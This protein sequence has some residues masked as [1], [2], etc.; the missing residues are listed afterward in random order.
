MPSGR[1]LIRKAVKYGALAASAVAAV[2]IVQPKH[3][4]RRNYPVLGRARWLMES[5]RPEIQQYFVESNT[6]GRPFDRVTRTMVYQ[7]AKN[8]PAEEAFGT[9]RDLFVPGHD[10]LLH[11]TH[12]VPA[13]TDAPLV[14]LGGPECTQPYDISLFNISSMSFGSLSANAVLAMNKGAA[15]GGFIQETGEGGLTKY[16]LEYGAD[17]IWEIGSS[18]FGCR[19]EDGHFDPEQFRVKANYPEVKGILIKLSQGAK[20]GMGGMLP[21]HKVTAEIAE[22]RGIEEGQDCL[23]PAWH[24]EFDTPLELMHFVKKLRRL[25][26]GKPVGIKFCVGSRHEVLSLCKAMLKAKTAPDWITVDGAEGGTGAAPLEFLDRVGTPLTE[27]LMIVHNALVG[28]GLRDQVAVGAAGKVVGGADIIRRLAIGADFTMS[29]RGMMM[30]AGCIQAKK[31]HDNTCPTGVATQNP[32]LARGLDVDSKAE[33][34]ANYHR[35]TLK[36]ATRILGAM[37]M[38]DVSQLGP[39]HLVRRVDQT[40]ARPYEDLYPWLEPGSLL[41]GK[42]PDDWQRDY[43]RATYDQYSMLPPVQGRVRRPGHHF[44]AEGNVGSI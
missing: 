37:G 27:G 22:A 31:C 26:N 18:Y 6:D 21:G 19:T 10:H 15:M 24:S 35:N 16:H 3:A 12:P 25:A 38:H 2:D 36:S 8:I 13:R 34:V 20:P 42:A 44:F 28:T 40:Q 29:A 5:I 9:Q 4:I 17:L 23:S 30:A 1:K 32:W 43:D 33:R 14:R 7:N 11:S 39:G 41:E